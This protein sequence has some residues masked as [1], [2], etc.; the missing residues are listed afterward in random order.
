[1]YTI[2]VVDDEQI[3]RDGVAF[4][5]QKLGYPF[6]IFTQCNGK[7]ALEFLQGT[8]VDVICSDIKMPFMDGLD[9]CEAAK[10]QYPGVKVVI[11]TAYNDFEY[12]KRAIRFH[13]DDYIM[14]PVVIPEFKS[15]MDRILSELDANRAER[16]KKYQLVK[17]YQTST[18]EQ[19]AGILEEMMGELKGEFLK[20]SD[21]EEPKVTSA[22]TA[23]KAV[24]E[25]I[26]KEYASDLTLDEL[27][28]RVCLSK[29]YL[30]N[31]FKSEI[32]MSITQ[33]ITLLRMQKAHK[34]LLTTNMKLG[35]IGEVVGYH[36][37]SYFCLTFKKYYG[38]TAQ[39]LR[40]GE[41]NE[42]NENLAEDPKMV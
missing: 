1:M 19:R 5:L 38:V 35:D 23:I 40:R 8:S 14:K 15:V 25:I 7:A 31:L 36:N 6:R 30:S 33:Y 4:L 11:L 20:N 3:E 27:A 39:S 34:L 9:F 2:L 28:E 17:L 41:S 10:K 21:E 24:M 13:V 42:E 22:H 16:E 12:T 29:G 18:P 32:G 26:E 37:H